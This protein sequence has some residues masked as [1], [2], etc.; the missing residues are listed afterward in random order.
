MLLLSKRAGGVGLNLR[1][2]LMILFEPEINDSRD[3]QVGRVQRVNF[4]WDVFAIHSTMGP[5]NAMNMHGRLAAESLAG[6]TKGP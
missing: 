6:D 3:K 2:R 4:T 5:P 1:A